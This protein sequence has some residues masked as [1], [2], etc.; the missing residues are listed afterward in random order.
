MRKPFLDEGHVLLTDRSANSNA[1]FTEQLV[2]NTRYIF[3]LHQ[4]IL[5]LSPSYPVNALAFIG[6]PS[7]IANCPS[8]IAQSLYVSRAILDPSLLPSRDILLRDL[9]ENE[10]KSRE[11]GYDPYYTGH[12]LPPDTSSDYQDD[13][14]DY[15]KAKAS[16]STFYTSMQFYDLLH[17]L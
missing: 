1:S 17:Q 15:L 11:D 4:H 5:S 9:A 12:K 3:P 14:V 16:I 6:L 10:E 13:L 7:F 2:T 8:D